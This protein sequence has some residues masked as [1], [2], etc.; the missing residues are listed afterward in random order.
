MSESI[1]DS[2]KETRKKHVAYAI[3]LL[4]VIKQEISIEGVKKSLSNIA[5][6]LKIRGL[7][8][9]ETDW[10]LLECLQRL[11]SRALSPSETARV[12]THD[13]DE[14]DLN[15]VHGVLL[16]RLAGQ[17]RKLNELRRELPQVQTQFKEERVEISLEELKETCAVLFKEAVEFALHG[18]TEKDEQA[19]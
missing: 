6:D 4:Y 18:L 8:S 2:L 19:S 17:N 9:D 10:K 7:L 16:R 3:M 1:H 13:I 15:L 14:V 11:F 12:L 5:H